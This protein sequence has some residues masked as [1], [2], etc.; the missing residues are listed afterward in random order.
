M[1]EANKHQY[2]RNGVGIIKR[3]IDTLYVTAD[4][5]FSSY[6]TLLPKFGSVRRGGNERDGLVT[7][8]QY[9]E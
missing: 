2:Y 4:A 5:L 6:F 1:L 7:L 3:R 8:T 9:A